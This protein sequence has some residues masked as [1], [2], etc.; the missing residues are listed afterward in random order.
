VQLL[1]LTALPR[2]S[3]LTVGTVPANLGPALVRI[4]AGLV[5]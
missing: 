3:R 5:H 1:V 2:H 4:H